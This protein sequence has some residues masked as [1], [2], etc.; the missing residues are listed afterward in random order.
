[1]EWCAELSLETSPLEAQVI[2][3]RGAIAYNTQAAGSA[4]LAITYSDLGIKSLGLTEDGGIWSGTDDFSGGTGNHE[5]ITLKFLYDNDHMDVDESGRF[6]AAD[7]DELESYLESTDP[8]L[9]ERFDFNSSGDIDQEDVDVLDAL[10]DAGLHAGVFGDALGDNGT[11][12]CPTMMWA[13][14]VFGYTLGQ[15]NY[16]I[17]L[18][19]DLDGDTDSA[20]EAAYDA[21][22]D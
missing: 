1:M 2:Q 19:Y 17:T 10:V 4:I 11:V 3:W 12:D 7:V 22:C 9:L 16:K 21:L 14:P 5:I 6:N 20:D 18:D 13:G 15:A 8:E